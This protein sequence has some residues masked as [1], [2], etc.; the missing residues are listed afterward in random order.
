M[1]LVKKFY[2]DGIRFQCQGTGKCCM[3]RGE[4]TYVYLDHHDRLLLARH[5]G[6]SPAELRRKYLAKT[7]GLVHLRDPAKDCVFLE[8]N[9]CAVYEA[10]PRQCR[11]WPFWPENMKRRVWE[12]EIVPFCAGIGK[13]RLYSA[14]EIEAILKLEEDRDG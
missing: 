8:N 9:R 5:L 4:N 7:H 11:T 6:V 3:A 13:G 10:R 1:S 12:T 14:A 2:A